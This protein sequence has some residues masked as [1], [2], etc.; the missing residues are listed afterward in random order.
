MNRLIC[1]VPLLCLLASCASV[2]SVPQG[3]SQPQAVNEAEALV[4]RQVD[5]YNKR[6]LE[7]FLDSYA[8]D[9]EAFNFPARLMGSGKKVFRD[10]YGE[11]FSQTPD[12]SVVISKRIVQGRF[13]IDEEHV[14]AGGKKIKATAIYQIEP[15]KIRRVWFIE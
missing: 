2:P 4:Q 10:I 13:V 5:A 14:T 8:D 6:D 1:L 12:L 9:A 7:A 15:G 11:L 3:V